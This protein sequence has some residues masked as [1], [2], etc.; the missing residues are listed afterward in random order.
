[1][2]RDPPTLIRSL[3]HIEAHPDFDRQAGR[4]IAYSQRRFVVSVRRGMLSPIVSVASTGTVAH[5]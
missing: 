2:A 3:E 1:M 4:G 5:V